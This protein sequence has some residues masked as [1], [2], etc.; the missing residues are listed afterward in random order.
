[1]KKIDIKKKRLKIKNKKLLKEGWGDVAGD[2]MVDGS[3]TKIATTALKG[4]YEAFKRSWNTCIVLPWKIVIAFKDGKDLNQV[5]VEWEQRD[6]QIKQAQMNIIK[7]TGVEGTVDAFIGV[8]N[9]SALMFQRF[10]EWEDAEMKRRFKAGG[11][12]L[13]NN[14]IAARNPDLKIDANEDKRKYSAQIVYS[15]FVISV[16]KAIRINIDQKKLNSYEEV[17]K[18]NKSFLKAIDPSNA[19]SKDNTN[20]RSFMNYLVKSLKFNS[21]ITNKSTDDTYA[22]FIEKDSS[23]K[24]QLD[25]IESSLFSVAGKKGI[26]NSR[27]ADII[28]AN[29]IG[30]SLEKIGEFIENAEGIKADFENFKTYGS[31]S[32]ESKPKAKASEESQE[33]ESQEEEKSNQEN[34]SENI[35]FKK[36]LIKNNKIS[37]VNERVK[38]KKSRKA[39]IDMMTNYY[40][41][42]L[43]VIMAAKFIIIKNITMMKYANTYR[44]YGDI[45]ENIKQENYQAANINP[46]A[47]TTELETKLMILKKINQYTQKISSDS[48]LLGQDTQVTK[49]LIDEFTSKKLDGSSVIEDMNS[50]YSMEDNETINNMIND[51]A[52]LMLQKS[53]EDNE[54][55]KVSEE[56]LKEKVKEIK[57]NLNDEDIKNINNILVSASTAR[58]WENFVK[59]GIV[60][61]QITE[62]SDSF[63]SIK[64]KKEE[65]SKVLSGRMKKRLKN[66]LPEIMKDCLSIIDENINLEQYLNT[67]SKLKEFDYGSTADELEKSAEDV[68]LK[69]SKSS[70]TEETEETTE[71]E[72]GVNS[73]DASSDFSSTV[74]K[75]ENK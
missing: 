9:P 65:L 29:S 71:E 17:E 47:F 35:A 62:I 73:L 16:C 31:S 19:V 70:S 69:S 48:Q 12:S 61:K 55:K 49:S 37:L 57:D 56:E 59:D 64:T 3:W 27:A 51:F 63:S 22:S 74:V 7:Q 23:L 4:T 26:S 45:M 41:T 39:F 44:I 67:M 15:N 42:H 5:M 32:E 54:N 46:E 58:T 66:T 1:M 36:L 52:T 20:Y 43:R 68:I 11:K 60:Q 33:E 18:S 34:V 50:R 13:W 6:K 40:F 28:L 10:V 24:N 75:T 25:I 2:M 38:T 30:R 21:S 14:T 72:S 53:D 8:C